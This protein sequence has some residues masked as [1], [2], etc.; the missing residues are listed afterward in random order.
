MKYHKKKSCGCRTHIITHGKTNHPIFNIWRG[1]MRRC[2]NKSDKAYENYG[3]RGIS[4][5]KHW[6]SIKNFIEDM[7][8]SF[9]EGLTLDRIDVNGNYT[10]DN[11]RWADRFTQNSN[12]QKIRSTNTSGFRGVTFD[13]SR[14]KYQAQIVV[15]HNRFFLGRYDIPER[16]ALAYDTYVRKHNL[17]H[18][19][20][21][22][23]EEYYKLLE[24]YKNV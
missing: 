1:M 15:K 14:N 13:K 5:C 24:K 18:T 3:G 4:V 20:N 10:P 11:C 6:H 2:Y 8:P 19:K 23:D 12:T 16:G 22:Y 21:F 17:E 7:Y 9:E